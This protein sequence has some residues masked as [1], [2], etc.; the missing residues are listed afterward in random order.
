[1][2]N[3]TRILKQI[4]KIL[5]RISGY[6]TI[7]L[8][9]FFLIAVFIWLPYKIN[10]NKPS[11]DWHSEQK[12]TYLD[13]VSKLKSKQTPN[14]II[15]FF[16]DL[17]YGDFSCYGNK[18]I[19]TPTIDSL[20]VQGVKFTNAYSSSPVCTSSRAGLLSGR[21]PIRTLANSVFFQT[22]ANM[23]KMR[24]FN[25]DV[26]KLPNDEILLPEVL[27][28]AGY[29]T[30]MI[31][32]WHL[33]DTDGHLPNDFGFDEFYGMRYSVDMLPLNIYRNKSIEFLDKTELVSG[34]TTY[35][36][37]D[38]A[39]KTKGIDLS[40]L[41]EKYTNEAVEFIHKN[42]D[43]P[44]FLY[45]AH[46]YPHVPHFASKKHTGESEGGLYGDVIEDLDRSTKAL[47]EALES[48]GLEENTIVII[49]SDNG[50]DYNGNAGNLRGR[51]METY[52]GGQRVPLIVLW[53][54]HLSKLVTD[55]M[56][57]NIDFFPTILSLLNIPLPDDR[58]MD[59]ENIFPVFMG[60]KSP[61]KY[62]YYTDAFSGEIKGIRDYRYKY[63]IG[64]FKA[65]PILN[66]IGV[67][68]R[69]KPQL[70]DLLLGNESHNLIK[71]FSQKADSLKSAM[72][73][74]TES[75]QLETNKR[76]WKN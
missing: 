39:I 69:Y 11:W 64:G 43:R 73:L 25:G 19:K 42:K 41:T 44:F 21:L 59:G 65:L 66:S 50:A 13:K 67:V 28:A 22:G 24:N 36:D 55:Q 18:L 61:H 20:A 47:M 4:W 12:T 35:T 29:K 48:N 76:G 32:K 38:D 37:E 71:K 74:K 16:D 70:N 56:V 15:I 63:H 57:M 7:A 60:E 45:F 23:A 34:K 72:Y 53:K 26:N 31:G 51:K 68:Q 17:G 49:T 54:N 27:K 30:G 14:I 8:I 58:I 10:N 6:F 62:L 9:V 75:L 1:M 3:F 5:L 46:A 40:E 2:N 52:E 33:G